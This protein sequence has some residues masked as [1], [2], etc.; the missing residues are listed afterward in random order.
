MFT[1]AVIG[2]GLI[3][4]SLAYALRGFRD[5][6]IVGYDAQPEVTLQAKVYGAIDVAA[7]S[8]AQAVGQA[9][10]C[11]FCADPTA[12][13]AGVEDCRVFFREGCVVSEVC[14]VKGE[15]AQRIPAILPKGVHYIGI[16]PMA[17]REVGGFVNAD[18]EL[19]KGAGFI[20][21]PPETYDV[22]ALV[23]MRE[24]SAYVGAGRIIINNAEL[25]DDII[26]YSS[27]LPHIAATALVARYPG[28]LSL[29]HT[30]GAFRDCTRIANI[31]ADLWTDLLT[32]NREHTLF[33]LGEYIDTLSAVYDALNRDDKEALHGYLTS[34]QRNKRRIQ[35]L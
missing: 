32:R 7:G 29:A 30:A 35:T 1:I 33:H 6:V 9:D 11:L 25:H 13:L 21:V 31:D 26:A 18:A 27:D 34:A 24:M 8:A 22:D 15:M 28:E 14:G 3:G 12:I 4:G 20:L 16:H 19:F 2:I 23:L 10:L 5:A 17:G